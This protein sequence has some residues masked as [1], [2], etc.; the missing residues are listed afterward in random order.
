MSLSS[1]K[2]LN[3]GTFWTAG[4]VIFCLLRNAKVMFSVQKGFSFSVRL[5][6]T[7]DRA[8]AQRWRPLVPWREARAPFSILTRVAQI[9][10]S[11]RPRPPRP[12]V[13][14]PSSDAD[15]HAKSKEGK[16]VDCITLLL[17]TGP[18]HLHKCAGQCTAEECAVVHASGPRCR[19]RNEF[20]HFLHDICAEL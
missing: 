11:V 3:Q 17:F 1:S 12:C 15:V 6:P 8:C 13:L 16:V 4:C 20:L 9:V 19:D 18:A 5:D 14:R 2:L 7:L 10:P